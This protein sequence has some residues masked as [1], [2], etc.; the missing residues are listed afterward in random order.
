MGCPC[1]ST[2][3]EPG[4]TFLTNTSLG[5]PECLSSLEVAL[6]QRD[7]AYAKL[8][9]AFL[10]IDE[11]RKAWDMIDG[12]V[13]C[14]TRSDP[15]ADKEIQDGVEAMIKALN[16]RTN[17]PKNEPKCICGLD[18]SPT[19]LR[20]D[21]VCPKHD[22]DYSIKVRPEDIGGN[23]TEKRIE[24]VQ[25]CDHGWANDPD[26]RCSYCKRPAMTSKQWDEI[27]KAK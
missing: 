17:K 20:T 6:N 3:H 10:Q 13:G 25:Y 2:A 7:E 15:V 21:I 27:H 8:D 23:L 16:P 18:S 14:E 26:F 4:C 1:R 22:G 24:P 12:W 5:P 9:A 19:G 11:I